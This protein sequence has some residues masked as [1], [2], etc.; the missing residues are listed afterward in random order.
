[1]LPMPAAGL[2]ASATAL[3]DPFLPPWQALGFT[4]PNPAAELADTGLL[5]LLHL[6]LLA[7]RAPR[8]AGQLLESS[9]LGLPTAAAAV[10]ATAWT[11]HLLR[12]GELAGE[13]QRLRSTELATGGSVLGLCV[14]LPV[15]RLGKKQV[16]KHMLP[17][18]HPLHCLSHLFYGHSCRALL[19]G[20]GGV[21]P[22]GGAGRYRAGAVPAAAAYDSGHPGAGRG[23]GVCRGG[24]HD[25]ARP[26][27]R[28]LRMMPL[29]SI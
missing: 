22:A 24:G 5:A 13:A 16:H 20:C 29:A 2:G 1:M 9:A 11:L 18:R 15:R 26:A 12:G 4:A 6:L 8:L 25:A 7:D 17:R 21:L 19:P 27:G 10:E 14:Q 28:E 23:A 3:G